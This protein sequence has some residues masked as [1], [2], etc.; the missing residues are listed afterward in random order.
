MFENFCV[1]INGEH[2][3]NITGM[4]LLNDTAERCIEFDV[5]YDA[6]KLYYECI[7]FIIGFSTNIGVL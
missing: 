3:E 1:F 2:M 5:Q 7:Q 6:M 4:T